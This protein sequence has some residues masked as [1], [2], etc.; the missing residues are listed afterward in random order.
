MRA[1]D[2]VLISGFYV[3]PLFHLP[4]QWV[5]RWTTIAH[6]ADDL[7]VRLSAGN[8]VA[9]RPND[10]RRSRQAA[11]AP[12]TREAGHARRSVPPGALRARPDAIALCDPPN[13]S[14]LHRRRAAPPHL[15]AGRPHRLG[16]RRRGCAGS[17]CTTDAIVGI[18][19]PNTVE[20][21]L[22]LLGVLRAGMIA[23]PLPLLWR[24]I[25]AAAALKPGRRASH[26]HQLRRSAQP[27]IAVSPRQSLPRFS[28][29]ATSAASA[30]TCPTA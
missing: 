12:G 8:L 26:H 14:K 6:P 16:D 1:L 18:Q 9:R 5:A 28:R 13:R 23:A 19:L 3:V 15:C 24:R 10:P 20:S 29:S 30:R 7:A 22:A 2:R 4:E 25:D 17:D 21:V 27:I 11:H